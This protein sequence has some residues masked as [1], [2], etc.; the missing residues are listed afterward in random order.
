M[1]CW[2]KLLRKK[3][4]RSDCIVVLEKVGVVECVFFSLRCMSIVHMCI[5]AYQHSFM[6]YI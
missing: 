2:N 5:N 6:S 4:H 3:Q 1:N